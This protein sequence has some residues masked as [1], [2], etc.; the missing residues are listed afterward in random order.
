MTRLEPSSSASIN[1]ISGALRPAHT[2]DSCQPAPEGRSDG[3]I[4]RQTAKL[5][6]YAHIQLLHYISKQFKHCTFIH[7]YKSKPLFCHFSVRCHSKNSASKTAMTPLFY[8]TV[9]PDWI[10]MRVVSLESPLKR[11]QPLYDFNF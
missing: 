7:C 9:R 5:F 8:F 6:R 1:S 11:H 10:C 2:G 4:W 3:L